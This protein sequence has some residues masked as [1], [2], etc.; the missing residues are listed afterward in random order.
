[1]RWIRRSFQICL[2]VLIIHLQ[3]V[4]AVEILALNLVDDFLFGKVIDVYLN[5]IFIQAQALEIIP[6]HELQEFLFQ[7]RIAGK[8]A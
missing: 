2:E 1:M 4:D 8:T 3:I 6:Y 5:A 7:N